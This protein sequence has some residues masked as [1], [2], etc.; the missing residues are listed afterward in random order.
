[1]NLA[2]ARNNQ[3]RRRRPLESTRRNFWQ[4]TGP[5]KVLVGEGFDTTTMVE[6]FSTKSWA[7]LFGK[8]VFD[9]DGLGSCACGN[10]GVMDNF[11]ALTSTRWSSHER[12]THRK[13]KEH[14]CSKMI[15]K[16]VFAVS[17]L[18]L[19]IAL[20]P[21]MCPIVFVCSI[22][23]RTNHCDVAILICFKCSHTFMSRTIL[24]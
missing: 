15:A 24:I 23:V 3:N 7:F 17:M 20:Y 5:V 11:S 8:L 2:D 9:D 18:Q 13:N 10:Q 12:Q 1:M 14:L 16:T 19:E 4:L 6:L 21:A 22:F